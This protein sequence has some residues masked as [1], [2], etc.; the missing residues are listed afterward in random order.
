MARQYLAAARSDDV[1]RR[2]TAEFFL[3]QLLPQATALEA[4]VT[5]GADVL[6]SVSDAM[7]AGR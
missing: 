4:Q 7:L 6:D 3:T 1:A 5:A 2:A